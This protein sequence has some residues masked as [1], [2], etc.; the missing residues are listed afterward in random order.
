[1]RDQHSRARMAS[2][3]SAML[4][5]SLGLI[6]GSASAADHGDSPTVALS[7]G[8]VDITDLYEFSS[9]N[10]RQTVFILNVNPGAGVTPGSSTHF[11]PRTL[12]SIKVD[13]DGDLQPNTVFTF[14]FAP[15]D[16]AGKVTA[17][18]FDD[19]FFFDLGGFKGS[20]FGEGTRRLCD[21]DK[22]DFFLGLNVDSIVLSVPN[23]VV[24]GRGKNISAW[25]TTEAPRGGRMV[26]I[27]QMGR[28]SINTVFNNVDTAHKSDKELFNRT[29]PSEQVG[30]GFRAHAKDVLTSLGAADPTALAGILIADVL[31]FKTG[32]TSGFLNGRRLADDVIDAELGLVTNGAVPSD[33]I[34]ND[35]T[36]KPG[37]PYLGDAN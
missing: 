14:D 32:D 1:M 36:F 37:F 3:A 30:L 11:G 25:A 9:A 7:L 28:P 22:T 4:I 27:D 6:P 20:V 13:T 24:G 12:Y 15:V 16:A 10:H 31:T 33:C 26:Q 8:E 29:Q 34:A 2:A 18:L 5:L 19:P 21:A 35:S 23:R 17:G